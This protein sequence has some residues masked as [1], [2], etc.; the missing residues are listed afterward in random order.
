M[1]H[2]FAK[3]LTIPVWPYYSKDFPEER[4]III[5][6]DFVLNNIEVFQK[7]IV[8][9]YLFDRP[10]PGINYHGISIFDVSSCES[11]ILNLSQDCEASE[12]R[13]LL[14]RFLEE[15]VKENMYVI[16]FGI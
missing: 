8:Y 13:D 16:H 12:E 10:A 1:T 15:A 14:I 5:S 3:S 11:F 7:P 2:E 9:S 6:D 4:T